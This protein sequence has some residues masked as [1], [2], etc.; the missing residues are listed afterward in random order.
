M[1]I[2]VSDFPSEY[3]ATWIKE[4]K[5][6]KVLKVSLWGWEKCSKSWHIS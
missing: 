4:Y 1:K 5:N 6:K 3:K 2:I